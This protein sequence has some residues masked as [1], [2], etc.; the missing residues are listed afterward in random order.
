VVAK[1][2]ASPAREDQMMGIFTVFCLRHRDVYVHGHP[3]AYLGTQGMIRLTVLGG[4]WTGAGR[5]STQNSFLSLI[6]P[7]DQPRPEAYRRGEY[8]QNFR[9]PAQSKPEHPSLC[10]CGISTASALVY[11]RTQDLEVRWHRHVFA[12]LSG[13]EYFKVF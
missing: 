3:R 9:R 7:Q 11:V 6:H 1:R 10:D 2:V 12:L 8:R 4:E 5:W 13:D